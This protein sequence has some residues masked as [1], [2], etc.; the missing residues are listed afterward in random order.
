MVFKKLTQFHS[1]MPRFFLGTQC[2]FTFPWQLP[3]IPKE[4]NSQFPSQNT[5]I[6]AKYWNNTKIWIFG[7]S[8]SQRILHSHLYSSGSSRNPHL[9]NSAGIQWLRPPQG[10]EFNSANN[11]RPN[12][13]QQQ[14]QDKPWQFHHFRF[15]P[16]FHVSSLPKKKKKKLKEKAQLLFGIVLKWFWNSFCPV[17][18]LF[19]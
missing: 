4:M 5:E 14:S 7:T 8:S 13:S 17:K 12:F 15:F 6:I 1:S 3:A 18:V 2:C 16:A 9:W 11:L 10:W 19:D